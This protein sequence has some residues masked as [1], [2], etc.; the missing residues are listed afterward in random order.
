[1]KTVLAGDIL[2]ILDGRW[3][4]STADAYAAANGA[5][6]GQ[7]VEVVILRDGQERKI[8]VKPLG[9]I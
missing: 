4:S 2:T 5:I 9:G 7:A 3:T 8:Q 1:M 6:A